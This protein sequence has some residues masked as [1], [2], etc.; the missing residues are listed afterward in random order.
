M[1][2]PQVTI[3]TPTYNV[4]DNEQVNDFDLMITMLGK[5]TYPYLDLLVMDNAS[6]DGTVD[7]LVEY[8]NE[9][10][11]AFYSE[12]DQGKFDAINKGL[13]RAKGKYVAF[14]S[15]DDFYHD[16]K[17]IENVVNYMEE[18]EADFCC[19]PS[20]CSQPDGTAF[21][22]EPAILNAFQVVPFPRQAVIFKKSALQELGYFDA[23]FRLLADYDLILRLLLNGYVGVQWGDNIVTAKLG[24][25]VN[26]YTTQSNAEFSHKFYKN[27]GSM[28]PMSDEVLDR[29][30]K[31]SE[32]PRPLLDKLAQ[33]FPDDVQEEF[34]QLYENMYN[35]RVQNS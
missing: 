14:L 30:V 34:Y 8:K 20:Y 24:D 17:G 15:C 16:I 11:L 21:L 25:K 32:I 22:F 28:Y 12:P 35:F 29:M 26:R 2:E 1:Y 10:S 13:V 27:Y 23:K 4:V 7:L 31:I 18:E 6:K 19:F 9:G 3:I 5:Q 33:Y